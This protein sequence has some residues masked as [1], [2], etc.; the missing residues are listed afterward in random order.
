MSKTRKGR[1]EADESSIKD[2]RS[3]GRRRARRVLF[4]SRVNFVCRKCGR[5]VK[6]PPKDAPPWFD[7]IW[8]E[9][10]RELDY[11]LQANHKTKDLTVNTEEDC[12]WLCAPCHKE[13]DSQT[14]KGVSTV[15]GPSYF[16]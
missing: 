5:T 8:P 2:W 7:E 4:A 11:S 16:G 12:E 10:N 15:S 14:E 6:E 3:T 1:G 9:E 13:E